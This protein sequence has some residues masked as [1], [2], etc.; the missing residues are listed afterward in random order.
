M[1]ETVSLRVSRGGGS[2]HIVF[3]VSAEALER[4]VLYLKNRLAWIAYRSRDVEVVRA[5]SGLLVALTE[6][7]G[8]VG[9]CGGDPVS[10]LRVL[11]RLRVLESEAESLLRVPESV[12]G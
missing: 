1:T 12:E 10:V 7:L 6:L 4:R 11:G 9:E 5:A 3:P 8:D 2:H